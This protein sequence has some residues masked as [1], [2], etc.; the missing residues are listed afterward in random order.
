MLC[1]LCS[2]SYIWIHLRH[3]ETRSL[4]HHV[5]R[6]CHS[7]LPGS[8]SGY[9]E[10]SL[11][12]PGLVRPKSEPRGETWPEH[13]RTYL[14]AWSPRRSKKSSATIRRRFAARR[15]AAVQW[16]SC[17]AGFSKCGC[18][19]DQ[20]W[21]HEVCAYIYIIFTHMSHMLLYIYIYVKTDM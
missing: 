16:T 5:P 21:S 8:F 20:C 2:I 15:Y 17:V 3:H 1:N 10:V 7:I 6:F 13:G 4:F 14:D 12:R 11:Q 18:I 19:L 9:L